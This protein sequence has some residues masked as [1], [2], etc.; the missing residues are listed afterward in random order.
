MHCNS[1]LVPQSVQ[2]THTSADFQTFLENALSRSRRK[3]NFKIVSVQLE[4]DGQTPSHR[5]RNL[6]FPSRSVSKLWYAWHE[7]SI[8]HALLGK[9]SFST[10]N[11][12]LS[13]GKSSTIDR[14]NFRKAP[15]RVE[16]MRMLEFS[17][18]EHLLPTTCL[19]ALRFT[20]SHHA[21]PPCLAFW[22]KFN[23]KAR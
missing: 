12:F 3:N 19:F 1:R 14:F 8:C 15:K 22:V 23:V 11:Y 5:S 21:R 20:L 2:N 4:E 9:W 10:G 16:H 7:I 17:F 6:G 13:N 18:I